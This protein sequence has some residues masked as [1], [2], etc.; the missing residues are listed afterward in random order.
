MGMLTL[1]MQNDNGRRKLQESHKTI[2]QDVLKVSMDAGTF[3]N[4]PPIVSVTYVEDGS[5]DTDFIPGNREIVD[6]GVN[7]K[8]I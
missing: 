6:D 5:G 4:M 7:R 8:L 2:V 1:F 3:N